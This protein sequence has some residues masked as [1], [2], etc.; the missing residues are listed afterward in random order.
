MA[1]HPCAAAS[2]PASAGAGLSSAAPLSGA[3][4][5]VFGVA[6]AQLSQRGGAAAFDGEPLSREH[7]E[8]MAAMSL[9][10]DDAGQEQLHGRLADASALLDS[11]E[12]QLGGLG[13]DFVHDDA[14]IAVLEG[15]AERQAR[16]RRR[17]RAARLR[18]TAL[19]RLLV[20]CCYGARRA[21]MRRDHAEW[22]WAAGQASRGVLGAR[23]FCSRAA[24]RVPASVDSAALRLSQQ[25]AAPEAAP[26]PAAAADLVD[27]LF[28]PYE[29]TK[30]DEPPSEAPADSADMADSADSGKKGAGRGGATSARK[31]KK[32][33]KKHSKRGGRRASGKP[34]KA[35]QDVAPEVLAAALVA[36]AEAA[37]AANPGAADAPLVGRRRFTIFEDAALAQLVQKHRTA[38]AGKSKNG[39]PWKEMNRLVLEEGETPRL[40]PRVCNVESHVLQKRWW[41]LCPAD[42]PNRKRTIR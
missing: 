34:A 32:V 26:P 5:A 15:A 37:L 3:Y 8:M 39:I 35:A 21:L 13:V 40:L 38:P 7:E 14:E 30:I 33:S 23:A 25:P 24:T 29:V 42:C 18:V 31:T 11:L 22:A 19:W 10:D 17:A 41:L 2:A 4:A 36:A 12:R 27:A 1:S 20:T 6:T 16:L 9:L 28:A